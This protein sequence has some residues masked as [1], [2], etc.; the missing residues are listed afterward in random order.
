MMTL[1]QIKE[2]AEINKQFLQFKN[3]M[4]ERI[5]KVVLD[6]KNEDYWRCFNTPQIQAT[7]EIKFTGCTKMINFADE[8][9]EIGDDLLRLILYEYDL[10]GFISFKDIT[11][12]DWGQQILAK[13][14]YDIM[15]KFEPL[16]S[17]VNKKELTERKI[18]NWLN[19]LELPE[20]LE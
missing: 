14:L 7:C 20:I 19:Q 1:E 12:H 8:Y 5:V 11:L 13:F 15:R 10:S 6:V 4:K 18:V 16:A 9:K 3:Y 17:Q 2:A